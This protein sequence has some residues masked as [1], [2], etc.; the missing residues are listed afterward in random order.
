MLAF[1]LRDDEGYYLRC[2]CIWQK[3]N[4]LPAPLIDRPVRSHEYVFQLTKSKKYYFDWEA[5]LEPYEVPINRWGGT[6]LKADGNSD[7]DENTKQKIYRN[8]NVRP[9]SRGR[10]LR[11]VWSINTKPFKGEHFA[12]FPEQ[13][14]ER[15]IL[16]SCPE[17]GIVLD[18]FMGSGTTA[19]VCDRLGRNYIGFDLKPEYCA[20]A[21]E[22]IE[23]SHNNTSKMALDNPTTI[24]L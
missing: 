22:R 5:V 12:S 20:I 23:S 4:A 9:D 3:P 19:V 1:A 11:S 14:V 21:D 8:R 17:R 16:A 2:D 18:I 13:L 6:E 24:E 7:W 15:T 10:R